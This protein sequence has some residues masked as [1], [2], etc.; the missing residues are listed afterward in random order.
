VKEIPT[1]WSAILRFTKNG[2]VTPPVRSLTLPK[3]FRKMTVQPRATGRI[4][5]VYVN[6]EVETELTL[7]GLKFLVVEFG[8]DNMR[9]FPSPPP[10]LRYPNV[11]TKAAPHHLALSVTAEYPDMIYYLAEPPT[12]AEL[13]EALVEE[14]TP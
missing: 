3:L 10:H 7:W 4:E 9:L 6:G 2:K 1:E 5:R 13:I 8:D 12:P 14:E 11:L